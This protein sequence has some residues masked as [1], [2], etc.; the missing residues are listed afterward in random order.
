MEGHPQVR[1]VALIGTG[2]IARSVGA[3]LAAGEVAGMR[4]H[5][6]LCRT[7]RDDLPGPEFATLEELLLPGVVVVEAASHEAVREYAAD[8]LVFGADFVC[9]SV[10]ALASPELRHRLA[11]AAELGRSRVIVP[12][13]A[14]GGLD[15]LRAAA[16]SG[17]DEVTI[18]QRKPARTLLSEVE[19][20]GLTEPRVVFDGSV[21]DVVLA[22][23]TT[24]NVAA[25]VALAGLGFER[26][27]AVVVADPSIQANQV[28]LT[29]RGSF[30]NLSLRLENVPS[31][32]PRTSAIVAYSVLSTLRRLGETLVVPG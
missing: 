32:N 28:L 6:F 25:S 17:L 20:G 9:V 19:A 29:A 16:G 21:A 14:T 27:R 31:A 12:S 1:P 11:V 3:C 8:V 18:E 5:G 15:L 4:L 22:Y 13:G 10:G 24:T 30:G 23:P 26:T 2:T 7:V